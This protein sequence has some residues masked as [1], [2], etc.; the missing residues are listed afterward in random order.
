MIQNIGVFGLV[1]LLGAAVSSCS[2]QKSTDG[3]AEV[4]TYRAKAVPV[5]R[6]LRDVG[7]RLDGQAPAR[8]KGA[9]RGVKPSCNVLN[10]MNSKRFN[11]VFLYREDFADLGKE[12]EVDE[13]IFKD[14]SIRCAVGLLEDG[15][16]IGGTSRD[17]VSSEMETYHVDSIRFTLLGLASLRYVFVVDRKSHRGAVLK[18]ETEFAGGETVV[19]AV[20]YDLVS[21]EAIDT[22]EATGESSEA[23]TTREFQTGNTWIDQDLRERTREALEKACKGRYGG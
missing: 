9:P 12:A 5:V 11:D 23:G 15:V 8:A 20:L 2:K 4:E 17:P 16:L 6:Q 19:R 14:E 22:I 7:S 1:M 10:I 3:K 21:G 13:R 18:S